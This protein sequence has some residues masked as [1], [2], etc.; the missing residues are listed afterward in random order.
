LASK[1]LYCAVSASSDS[2]NLGS[3]LKDLNTSF[4]PGLGFGFGLRP[5]PGPPIANAVVGSNSGVA[6]PKLNPSGVIRSLPGSVPSILLRM[7]LKTL[8]KSPPPIK[9]APPPTTPPRIPPNIVAAFTSSNVN[10]SPSPIFWPA[11]FILAS[12]APLPTCLINCVPLVA[13]GMFFKNAAYWF[14]PGIRL[15][16]AAAPASSWLRLPILDG[17]RIIWDIKFIT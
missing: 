9:S 4:W 13:F 11:T 5:L 17:S 16:A 14:A 10:S 6:L 7:F 1:A 15:D 2:P 8:G 12:T 3:S